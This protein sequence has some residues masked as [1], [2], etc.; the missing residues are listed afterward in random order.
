[1]VAS[2]EAEGHLSVES[3]V[4]RESRTGRVRLRGELDLSGVESVTA[5]LDRLADQDLETVQIDASGVTFLDSSGLR[6]LLSG[7]EK[8]NARGAQLKVVDASLA[9][10]RV[11]EMTATRSILEG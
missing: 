7:R 3:T 9:V 5:E 8:L 11:L 6:A 4:D 2:V 1:M 10:T